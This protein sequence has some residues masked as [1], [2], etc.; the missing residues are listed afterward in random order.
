[1][2]QKACVKQQIMCDYDDSVFTRGRLE[3]HLGSRS[4]GD[5]LTSVA[6]QSDGM[7][8]TIRRLSALTAE[9]TATLNVT[10]F[11]GSEGHVLPLNMVKCLKTYLTSQCVTF[12]H[13]RRTSVDF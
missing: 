10:R 6:N 9:D 3:R 13:R 12:T 5:T 2:K 7:K 1:M 11:H 4:D 8:R